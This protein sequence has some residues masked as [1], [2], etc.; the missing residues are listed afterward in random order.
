M[1]WKKITLISLAI[2]AL[3][4]LI[5]GFQT[6]PQNEITFI[7]AFGAILV[8]FS[9]IF[10]LV[11]KVWQKKH[12]KLSKVILGIIAIFFLFLLAVAMMPKTASKTETDNKLPGTTNRR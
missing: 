12:T 4:I 2:F 9:L 10:P 7:T 6:G 3:G 1:N 8:F 11:V 5:I